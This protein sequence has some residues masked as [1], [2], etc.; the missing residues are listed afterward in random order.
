MKTPS[1]TA[2]NAIATRKISDSFALMENAMNSATISV[3][4]ERVQIISS[5]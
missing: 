3:T 1:M 5:I 2:K 4:G